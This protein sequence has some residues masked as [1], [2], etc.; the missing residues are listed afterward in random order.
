MRAVCGVGGGE[1]ILD[2]RNTQPLFPLCVLTFVTSQTFSTKVF[3][4]LQ[5]LLSFIKDCSSF[6]YHQI[7]SYESQSKSGSFSPSSL[8]HC[9][10]SA[11]APSII[12]YHLFVVVCGSCRL[13][14][15]D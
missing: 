15:A 7:C 1:Y 10:N 5:N 3:L 8:V 4:F 12:S 9:F 14:E 6:S 2:T 13:T 11:N